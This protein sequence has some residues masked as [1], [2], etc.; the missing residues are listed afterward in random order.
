VFKMMRIALNDKE[1]LWLDSV[2]ATIKPD[3]TEDGERVWNGVV[4]AFYTTLIALSSEGTQWATGADAQGK[5]ASAWEQLSSG[6]L[7][8]RPLLAE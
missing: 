8:Y 1:V 3:P 2:S 6:P 7:S 4:D 5:I